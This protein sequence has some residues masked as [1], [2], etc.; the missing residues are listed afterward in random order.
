MSKKINRIELSTESRKS[1]ETEYKL[2]SRACY[3]QRCKMILLNWAG[4][5]SKEIGVI[6][7]SNELSVNK[8]IRRYNN[9]RISGLN[10]KPGQ[11]CKP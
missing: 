6:L 8:W 7:G 3:R 1:L 9:L 10:T 11:G 4:Y 5:S 2:G